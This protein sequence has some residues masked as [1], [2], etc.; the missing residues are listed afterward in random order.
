M[1]TITSLIASETIKSVAFGLLPDE[2]PERGLFG[3]GRF[4]QFL[5][6]V[7]PSIPSRDAMLSSEE[8]LVGLLG[9]YLTNAPLRLNSPISPI[10]H[11]EDGV[12]EFKTKDVRAFGWF[13]AKDCA[14]LDSGCDVKLLK[15]N[16]INYSGYIEQT[17]YVR[18]S[19]GF[20]PGKFIQGSEPSHVVTKFIVAP[21]R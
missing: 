3:T 11:L 6:T 14:I 20:T 2:L 13:V 18:T 15:S 8:Q 16:R 21:K 5:E 17:R 19:L 4:F 10:R 1:S 9:R 7:L 12:W